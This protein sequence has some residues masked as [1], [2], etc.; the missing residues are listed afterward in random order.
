MDFTGRAQPAH[1]PVPAGRERVARPAQRRHRPAGWLLHPQGVAALERH[2]HRRRRGRGR[3]EAA[4]RLHP[5]PRQRQ[6][7]RQRRQ[8]PQDLLGRV[9]RRLRS[10]D[11][12]DRRRR[13][14]TVPTSH[15]GVTSP[16][17]P[18]G[19]SNRRSASPG[20]APSTTMV[21]DYVVRSRDPDAQHDA[22]G[23]VRRWA[24]QLPVLRRHR[25][26]RRQPLRP[27]AL[28]APQQA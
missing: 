27:R 23:R 13:A 28:V 15:R 22:A 19:C 20:S 5:H 10:A 14:R 24:R 9:R 18:A 26:G 11:R 3:L 21:D 17:S 16:T 2:R 6:P 7:V 12:G 8:R 25:R 1:Q 4:Q